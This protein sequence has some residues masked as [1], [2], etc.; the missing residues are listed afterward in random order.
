MEPN[1][2]LGLMTPRSRPE[3]KSRVGHLTDCATEEPQ[4]YILFDAFVN[5]I[6]FLMFFQD[7]YCLFMEMP[8]TFAC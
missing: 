1:S 5:G 8:L 6:I 3:L 4:Y 7:G 2:G